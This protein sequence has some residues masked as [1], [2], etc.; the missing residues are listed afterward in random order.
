MR[1]SER[2]QQKGA[3]ISE[4]LSMLQRWRKEK[5]APRERTLAPCSPWSGWPGSSGSWRHRRQDGR[6]VMT[7]VT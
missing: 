1:R 6:P 5:E 2:D 3:D 4:R 7:K